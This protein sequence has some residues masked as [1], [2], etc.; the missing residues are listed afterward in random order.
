M[1]STTQTTHFEEHIEIE[2]YRERVFLQGW[3]PESPARAL[4]CLVHGLGEH[5]GRYDHL[6]AYFNRE[7]IAV[8]V[9]DMRGHG[10]SDGPR[11]HFPGYPAI[12]AEIDG[13]LLEG[14]RRCAG[15]PV[16]LYGHSM[17][18]NM[19]LSY[20]LR[21]QSSVPLAGSIA[22]GPLLRT[23]FE[24]PSW[25]VFMGK[26]L[27][28]VWPGFSMANELDTKGLARDP[29]VASKYLADPL[30]HNRITPRFMDVMDGGEY[31][32]EHA[33]SLATPLLLLH[34]ERDPITSAPASAEFAEKAGARCRFKSWPDLLHE[35]HNEPEKEEVFA[36]EL[37]W[38][39]E[40]IA[41]ISNGGRAP[42]ST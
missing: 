35:I 40:R 25:K 36:C 1:V 16:F 34:G 6:A 18:G 9:M 38:M 17:G 2:G 10:R 32:I 42:E 12:F 27:Y 31:L 23:A 7:G 29:E 8:T 14:A 4:I 20:L 3:T 33:A 24:P 37:A 15:V 41:A 13:L 5:G 30:V 19:V 22:T 26:L 11:G 28:A 39:E 21:H